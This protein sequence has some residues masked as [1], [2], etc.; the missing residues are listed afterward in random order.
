[1]NHIHR[2]NKAESCTWVDTNCSSCLLPSIL[3]CISN[4]A[5]TNTV[6]HGSIFEYQRLDI[7]PEKLYTI[8]CHRRGVEQLVARRA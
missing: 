1:M 2:D 3:S 4:D 6:G 5:E 8:P 7:S